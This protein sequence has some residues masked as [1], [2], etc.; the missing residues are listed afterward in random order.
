[1]FERGIYEKAEPQVEKFMDG[2]LFRVLNRAG[3][4]TRAGA[5]VEK[6][7]SPPRAIDR[8]GAGN[9]GVGQPASGPRRP[10]NE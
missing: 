1:M 3:A 10:C 7:H 6:K 2:R 4:W 9:W 5:G 8:G